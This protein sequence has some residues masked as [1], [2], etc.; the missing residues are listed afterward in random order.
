MGQVP[1]P[2]NR[3]QPGLQICNASLKSY[4]ANVQYFVQMGD[5]TVLF[6]CANVLCIFALCMCIVHK[7]AIYVQWSGPVNDC[8]SRTNR[9]HQP[10]IQSPEQS[11]QFQV[12]EYFWKHFVF[13]LSKFGPTTTRAVLPTRSYLLV[14]GLAYRASTLGTSVTWW[15]RS[16]TRK[17]QS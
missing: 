5:H 4:C 11:I 8:S 16:G 3:I 7:Y 12:F 6:Q 1:M 9:P 13:Q 10:T 2:A 14:I 15:V 17:W